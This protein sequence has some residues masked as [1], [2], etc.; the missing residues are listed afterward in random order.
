MYFQSDFFSDNAE[1]IRHDHFDADGSWWDKFG[2]FLQHNITGGHQGV[3]TLSLFSGAGGLDIG[4]HDA[5]FNIVEAVELDPKLAASLEANVGRNKY[6]GPNTNI[7]IEDI[8]NYDPDLKEIEFII[9]GPPCQTFSAAGARAS[10][11]AGTKDARGALFEQYVRILRKLKPKGF[12]FENVYRILG[13][14]GGKD[15]ENIRQAFSDVGY[16]LHF[17]VLD[18]ADY[19][20]PQHRE[21]LIIVGVREDLKIARYGFPT[22]THGPD[23]LCQR[24]HSSSRQ[25][26][27]GINEPSDTA[28]LGGRYGHLL[29]EVP[30]GLNYSFFTEKMGHPNPIFSWRSKFSDFLYKA[31]PEAPVRTIKAQGGQYT[32]PFHWESRPFTQSEIKRLQ[33]FPD[34]YEMIGSKVT[35]I[36]QIGN[37]VPPQFAR[38]LALSVREQ[39]F[40]ESIPVALVPMRDGQPLSF[41]K[42]KRLRTKMYFKKAK[43]ALASSTINAQEKPTW[44]PTEVCATVGDDFTLSINANVSNRSFVFGY[45]HNQLSISDIE[46]EQNAGIEI[47]IRPIKSW[48]LPFNQVRLDAFHGDWRSFTTAWKLF[49]QYLIKNSLKADLEQLNGYYQYKPRIRTSASVKQTSV[50]ES[51]NGT[52]LAAV[53]TGEIVGKGIPLSTLADKFALSEPE[54]MYQMRFLKRIGYAVRTSNT[55]LAMDADSILLPY[56]FPTLNRLSVQRNKKI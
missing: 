17:R 8:C 6:F 29:N 52:L 32:G 28:S 1:Q 20:V 53:L 31:D 36:K 56:A 26:L 34:R 54:I 49:E 48:S 33:T 45:N 4:F 35:I 9:G 30:P 44:R 15:W 13:A 7:I 12:L 37:S 55:N 43:D 10:G 50:F 27:H 18:T 47:N 42:V 46:V 24:P 21:R 23:S 25:A 40:K 11:V 19:G 5:G 51:L 38:I 39:V 22:P 2:D 41:R 14:N 16:R 3:R